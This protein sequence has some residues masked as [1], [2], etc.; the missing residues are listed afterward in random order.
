MC[1]TV[2]CLWCICRILYRLLSVGVELCIPKK[3]GSAHL[4]TFT[5]HA[6]SNT[7]QGLHVFLWIVSRVCSSR[8]G[9]MCSL[10]HCTSADHDIVAMFGYQVVK[11]CAAEKLNAKPSDT[12]C[13]SGNWTT[14]ASEAT[15]Q[16]AFWA[17]CRIIIVSVQNL[18]VHSL[19]CSLPWVIRKRQV[20]NQLMWYH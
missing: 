5:C 10:R 13:Y 4:L 12:D 9:G 2:L 15:R 16:H 14:L 6:M 19:C 17:L 3:C 11:V 20:T 8:S 18:H 1:P 7:T